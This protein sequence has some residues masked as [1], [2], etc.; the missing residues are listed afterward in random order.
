MRSISAAPDLLAGLKA[1]SVRVV[2]LLRCSKY[3]L[4]S[5]CHSMHCSSRMNVMLMWYSRSLA[6]Y[7]SCKG[8]VSVV[9]TLLDNLH[10]KVVTDVSG[11]GSHAA[12]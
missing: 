3:L 11:Y 8:A 10:S 5:S 12:T 7:G 9:C 2:P 4:V 6:C 1:A